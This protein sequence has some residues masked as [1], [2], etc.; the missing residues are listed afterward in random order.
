MIGLTLLALLAFPDG[1]SATAP[2]HAPKY[3]VKLDVPTAWRIAARETDEYI[4]VAEIAQADP[5]RPGAAACELGIAPE[6]LDEYRV[7]IDSNARERRRPGKL[8]SN[9]IVPGSEGRPDLL[10]SLWELRPRDGSLWRELTVRVIANHQLYSFVL[11]VDEPTWET[12][13]PAFDALVRSARFEPPNTG[14]RRIEEKSNRWQQDEFR[15]AV[16]LPEGWRPVLAPNEVALL[17]AS[18]PPHGVWSDNFLVLA[19]RHGNQDLAELAKTLPDALHREEPGC[20][21]L[22][23]VVVKQPGGEALETVVRTRRGPFSMTVLER[24]FRGERF[25]YEAKFTVESERFDA[26]A[27]AMRRSLE[28]FREVEGPVADPGGKPA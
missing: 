16:D 13:R 25:D 11:N 6:S 10:E 1:A 28:S 14:A 24:R 15:F 19:Q 26:L 20:E 27:P 5:D 8:L 17:F 4:L 7:R 3:G 18:G 21:V 23:C 9:R 2:F 22:S 12:A